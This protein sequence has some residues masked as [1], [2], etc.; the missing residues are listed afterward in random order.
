[1]NSIVFPPNKFYVSDRYLDRIKK[2]NDR[3]ESNDRNGPFLSGNSQLHVIVNSLKTEFTGCLSTGE[4]K[5]LPKNRQSNEKFMSES[6]GQMG[7]SHHNN[8]YSTSPT[9]SSIGGIQQNKSIVS[10]ID[11]SGQKVTKKTGV[12]K[13]LMFKEE[14][15]D[16]DQICLEC[17]LTDSLQERIDLFNSQ[18]RRQLRL[19]MTND[20]DG[21]SNMT[22][23]ILES[24]LQE[25]VDICN[26]Q[27]KNFKLRLA[28]EEV[29]VI[30]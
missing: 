19:V 10:N 20:D 13:D 24:I 26:S 15:S 7:Q 21:T 11:F 1:M 4:V 12:K 25:Q 16:A 3:N 14:R 27:F 2:D 22:T 8:P 29:Q 30:S 5:Q 23:P 18:Q 17:Q 28:M 9:T 6:K